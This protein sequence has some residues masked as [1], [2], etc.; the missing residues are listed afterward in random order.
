MSEEAKKVERDVFMYRAYIA[1]Q[2][3][4]VVI[5]ET[6]RSSVSELEAVHLYANYMKLASGGASADKVAELVKVIRLEIN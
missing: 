6:S 1:Q 2:K 5:G 4:E 3:Y